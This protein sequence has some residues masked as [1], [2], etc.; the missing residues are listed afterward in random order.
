MSGAISISDQTSYDLVKSRTR[1]INSLIYGIALEFD[2][3]LNNAAVVK[4]AKLQ[5]DRT[6]LNTN[7]H[8]LKGRAD[9]TFTI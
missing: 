8:F 3:P 2:R 7:K 9:L 1:E 6:V 5:S 4:P